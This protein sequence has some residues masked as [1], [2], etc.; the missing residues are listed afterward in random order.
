MKEPTFQK[1]L[2]DAENKCEA[3]SVFDVNGDGIDDIVLFTCQFPEGEYRASISIYAR[4]GELI[5]KVVENS[6]CG[7]TAHF[8]WDGISEK[9]YLVPVD[10]YIVQLDY[11]NETGK[12]G[13]VRKV[14]GVMN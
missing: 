4:T 3:C 5:K 7:S 2:I 10:I 1:V 6:Y 14:L 12:R 11:W 13:K 8:T 9:N